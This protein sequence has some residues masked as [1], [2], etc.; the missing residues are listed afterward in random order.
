MDKGIFKTIGKD[1]RNVGFAIMR[2]TVDSVWWFIGQ[3]SW[4]QRLVQ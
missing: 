2:R 1:V 3:S 4:L